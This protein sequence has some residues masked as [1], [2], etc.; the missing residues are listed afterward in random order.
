[1]AAVASRYARALADI[2]LD[3]KSHLTGEEALTQIGA[4]EEVLASSEDLR[5][6]LLSPAVP[7]GR[8]RAVVRE[9]AGR[10]QASPLI[11][12][13]LYVVIDHRRITALGE[14]RKAFE[15]YLDENAGIVRAEVTS[16]LDL[17]EQQRA[18]VTEKLSGM[19]GKRVRS[20]FL[21][22]PNLMGGVV[23][24]I[25]ST[26]YD[27]SVRGQLQSLRTKLLAEA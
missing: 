23:A 3:P 27:G 11:L 7:P 25:G 6:V 18:A 10:L 16:A 26:I 12:N 1:M 19:T 8:K 9:L 24:R 14:I 20:E 21:V 2:V 22:D 15:H 4:F 13:F 17:T 5:N